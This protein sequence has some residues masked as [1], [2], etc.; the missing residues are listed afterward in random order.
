M[1]AQSIQRS[2][3][4]NSGLITLI[5]LPLSALFCAVAQI[6][7]YLYKFQL[8]KVTKL[9]VPVI[10]VGNISVGGT[11]KTPL[12]IAITQ[13]LKANGFNPGVISRGYG[14]QAKQWPQAVTPE[15]DPIQVG[16][17]TVLIA[18]RCRCPVSV[19]PDRVAA[20]QALL[21]AESCDIIISDDGMQHYALARDIEIAVIDGERRLGNALC[22]PAG[23]LRELPSRLKSVDLIVTN[24]KGKGSECSMSLKS[25]AFHNIKDETQLRATDA[26]EG[27]A[28]EAV[29]G[30]GNNERFFQQLRD[31][32]IQVRKHS[33]SDHHQYRENELQF[34]NSAPVLMT[35]KD[36]IKCKKFSMHDAWYLRVDALLENRF[37]E[38]LTSLIGKSN[39]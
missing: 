37:Y 18:N 21:A 14:G 4:Q 27:I 15:S 10:V 20:A 3:Y 22:L 34:D 25:Y 32:G 11:G 17:E 12:V 16:D 6:R 24:G 2:W 35:E 29:S 39:G 8:L 7:R 30:I 9:P 23:P 36:A 33:F 19:G 38:K 28:V 5:L 31:L 26:F 1:L 13:Y